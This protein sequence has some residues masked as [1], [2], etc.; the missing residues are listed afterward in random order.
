MSIRELNRNDYNELA[1]FLSIFAAPNL[2][3]ETYQKKFKIWWDLNTHCEDSDLLG[4]VIVD[5]NEKPGNQIK[6][7]MGNI[8]RKYKI[9]GKII[10]TANATSWFV[11]PEY[12]KQAIFLMFAYLKQ[13]SDLL[14]NS[15]SGDMSEPIFKQVGF[16][17]FA[18]THKSFLLISNRKSLKHFLRKK[19]SNNYLIELISLLLYPICFFYNLF[20]SFFSESLELKE[21]DKI[22]FKNNEIEFLD[23]LWL[24]SDGFNIKLH[25]IT[26]HDTHVDY[27]VS[28]YVQNPVNEL[29][30]IQILYSNLYNLRYLNSIKSELIS[31]H[32][33]ES[34]FIMIS[35]CKNVGWILT[36]FIDISRYIHTTCFAM[37]DQIKLLNNKHC[38][39][40][41][42]EKGFMIWN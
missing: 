15:T 41:F 34:D 5:E 33:K 8:P 29:N 11:N 32:Q 24:K 37:G 7:F 36:G 30:Y 42:G 2:P 28:Q 14:V 9:E 38:S 4:W 1:K 23:I 13:K 16:T 10:K 19:L 18:I 39:S 40:I 22:V 21:C 17:N 25:E 26:K 6:G 35:N 27:I 3:V 31:A 20:S 12:R